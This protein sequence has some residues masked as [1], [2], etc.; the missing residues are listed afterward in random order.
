MISPWRT[1]VVPSL[2]IECTPRASTLHGM[3]RLE[4]T[5]LEKSVTLMIIPISVCYYSELCNAI[6]SYSNAQI[7]LTE[8]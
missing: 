8:A 3:Y 4:E 1:H 6:M 5:R 2:N 7:L